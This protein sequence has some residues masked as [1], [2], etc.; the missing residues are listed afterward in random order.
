MSELDNLK[1]EAAS[2]G[3]THS[4]Q[5]G[6]EKLK[7]KIE[8]HY[9]SLETSNKDIQAL[10][11]E[12]EKE[13]EAK[14]VAETAGQDRVGS[15][16]LKRKAEAQKTRVITITDNDQRINNH[17]TTCVVNCSNQF[18]SL[19]TVVLPL[20]EKIEVCQGHINVLKEVQITMHVRD[21]K[22]GLSTTRLRKRYSISYED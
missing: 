7:E 4:A 11:K 14:T 12:K 19:G 22:T 5:I 15:K 20:N 16:K 10:V 18:F 9:K 21:S 3:I 13:K 2:L 6:E 8:A 1:N 17:S